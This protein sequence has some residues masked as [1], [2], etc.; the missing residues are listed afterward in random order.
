MD[1]IELINLEL[2]E[3]RKST[4]ILNNIKKGFEGISYNASKVSNDNKDIDTKINAGIIARQQIDRCKDMLNKCEDDLNQ[5]VNKLWE[6]LNSQDA[7]TGT[8]VALSKVP[9]ELINRTKKRRRL[10]IVNNRRIKN[11]SLEMP[12]PIFIS[13]NSKIIHYLRKDS[14]APKISP[15][16]KN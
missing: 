4:I 15:K 13:I 7:I 10:R 1:K 6:E 16:M 9:M 14:L 3:I 11:P 8:D 12:S 5:L 2:E